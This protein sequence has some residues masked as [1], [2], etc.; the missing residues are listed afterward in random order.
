MKRLV[1]SQRI[2]AAADYLESSLEPWFDRADAQ[3]PIAQVIRKCAAYGDL[4]NLE[5]QLA[6]LHAL[7]SLQAHIVKDIAT[8][9]IE[10]GDYDEDEAA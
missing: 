7:A 8:M 3:S 9:T 10:A 2:K 4:T 1:D 6:V 5:S